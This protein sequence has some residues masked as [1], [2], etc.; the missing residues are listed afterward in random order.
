MEKGGSQ[1]SA[2]EVRAVDEGTGIRWGSGASKSGRRRALAA[3]TLAKA[4]LGPRLPGSSG[5]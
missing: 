4:G 5:S 3:G 2:R 1:G